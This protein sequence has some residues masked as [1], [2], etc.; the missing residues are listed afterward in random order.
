MRAHILGGV[1]QPEIEAQRELFTADRFDPASIFVARESRN[2]QSRTATEYFDFHA[3]LTERRDIKAAVESNQGVKD[4]EELMRRTML[5]WWE[6]H[7]GQIAQLP[8]ERLL[9]KTRNELLTTFNQ[10]DDAA[11]HVRY[12]ES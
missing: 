3:S 1:P 2:S 12:V 10:G 6:R 7:Q 11:Q 4:K 8:V 5:E 9:M